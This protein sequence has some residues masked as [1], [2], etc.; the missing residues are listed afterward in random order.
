MLQI[1]RYLDGEYRLP[2]IE[3]A[4]DESHDITRRFNSLDQTLNVEKALKLLFKLFTESSKIAS[5]LSS[6]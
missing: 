4:G 1:Y 6:T 5:F 2:K 3:E